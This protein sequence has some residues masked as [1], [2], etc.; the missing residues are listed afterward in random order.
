MIYAKPTG[1]TPILTP[2]IGAL[3]RGKEKK[4]EKKK[5]HLH[6]AVPE[7]KDETNPQN[8]KGSGNNCHLNSLMKVPSRRYCDLHWITER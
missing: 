6:V 8:S 4:E 5:A 2:P 1:E 3:T 7:T